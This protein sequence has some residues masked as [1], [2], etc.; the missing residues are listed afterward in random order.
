[1]SIFV[2][3]SNEFISFYLNVFT[4]VLFLTVSVSGISWDSSMIK[5][6]Q[7]DQIQPP[8]QMPSL[9]TANPDALP[10]AKKILNYLNQLPTRQDNRVIAGQL[11]SFNSEIVH[12]EQRL[13][14]IFE[15]SG[16]WPGLT[17]VDYRDWDQDH[18]DN[19]SEPNQFLIDQ[20]RQ[21]SLVTVSW[22]ANNPWTGEDSTD[23]YIGSGLNELITPGT[24]AHQNWISMLDN[25]ASGLQ[26]LQDAGVVVIWRPF[27]EMNGGWFW[28]YDDQNGE[29]FKA[30][31]QHMFN[32]FTHTKGLNNLLWA[33]SP[34]VP[35]DPTSDLLQYYPGDAYVDIVGLDYYRPLNE[36]PI[37]LDG[38]SQLLT[39]GKPI[40]IF[41]FGPSP[42]NAD[43]DRPNYDYVKLIRDIRNH[44]PQ[45][46]M[47]QAW[48]WHWAIPENDNAVGLMDDSWIITRNEFPEW[49]KQTYLPIIFKINP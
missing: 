11:G 16:K 33:F 29:Q 18:G 6:T 30:L 14:A 26:E 45:I 2:Q 48:E 24:Q 44:Y 49:V 36:D 43:P 34:N 1:M 19:L 9:N 15:Q 39:V 41:E 46:V 10:A 3:K 42:A 35:S 8:R 31:W 5:I 22:H 28:W 27:H 38:Y 23:M 40:A 21:G 37:V 4:A 32:Y 20:W 25:I 12:G 7:D 17:G 47:F 13:Q